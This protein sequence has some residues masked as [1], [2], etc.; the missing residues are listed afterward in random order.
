M[1]KTVDGVYEM[2]R[3]SSAKCR[4]LSRITPASS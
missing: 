2:A 1:L 3:S 4:M